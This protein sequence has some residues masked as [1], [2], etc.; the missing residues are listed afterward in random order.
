MRGDESEPIGQEPYSQAISMAGVVDGE[1]VLDLSGRAGAVA[2][3]LAATA[4]SVE[5]MQLDTELAEEGRRLAVAM[6]WRNVYFHPGELHRLPFD[7]GQF[8][9]VVWCLTLAQEPRPLATLHEIV[10]VMA[11]G[12]RLIVQDV[13]AFGQPELDLKLWELERDRNPRHLLFYTPGELRALLLL[14]GLQVEREEMSGMTQDFD[15]W[16][17]TAGPDAAR[18]ADLK[19]VFFSM[20]PAGQDRLDLALADGRISFTYPVVTLLARPAS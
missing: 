17:D 10:R 18:R 8:D 3:Q 4:S 1:R 20:P 9:L 15:Y 16:A 7:P 13:A 2:L 11:P 5:A 19:R 12:G 14:A 6:G